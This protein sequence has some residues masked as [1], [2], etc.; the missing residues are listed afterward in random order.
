[1]VEVAGCTVARA[2]LPTRQLRRGSSAVAADTGIAAGKIHITRFDA[3]TGGLMTALAA[4][5]QVS[6]VTEPRM[7]EPPGPDDRRG[8]VDAPLFSYQLVTK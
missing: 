1:M 4:C 2:S 3:L 6:G 8:D 7:L 5:A